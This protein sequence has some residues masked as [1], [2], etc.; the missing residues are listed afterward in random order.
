MGE[1][2][3]PVNRLPPGTAIIIGHLPED[4]TILDFVRDH[5]ATDGAVIVTD[6]TGQKEVGDDGLPITI[7]QAPIS[8]IKI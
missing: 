2:E 6:K 5:I 7:L 4:S 3:P 1:V 8:T